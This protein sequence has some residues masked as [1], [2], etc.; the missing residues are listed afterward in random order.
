MARSA[1]TYAQLMAKEGKYA[2]I[3]MPSGEVRKVLLT[4]KATIGQI[5]ILDRKI[6][7]SAR[8]AEAAGWGNGH[9]LGGWP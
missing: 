8:P 9:S 7:P 2:Q 6:S 4:C 5:G 1:G 3:K